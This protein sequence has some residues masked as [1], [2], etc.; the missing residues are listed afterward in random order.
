MEM[1]GH[2]HEFV[3]EEPA[4][5][6]ILKENV[7]KQASHLWFFEERTASVHDGGDEKRADFLRSIV[8]KAPALK[9][10]F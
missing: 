8:N 7:K 4:F 5:A 1:V 6:P 9:R 10:V 3:D 2:K